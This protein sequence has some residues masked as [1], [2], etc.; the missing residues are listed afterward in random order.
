MPELGG[1]RH[2]HVDLPGYRAHVAEAGDPGGEPLVMVHGWPQ[3]WW[4]WHK[5]IPP[6]SERYRVICPDLRGHGWSDAPA[7]GYDKPQFARDLIALL[8]A[9]RLDRVRLMGHD[10]GGMAGFLAGIRAPERFDRFL[11]LGIAPPFPSGDPKQLLGLWRLYYQ[12]PLTLPVI[13]P[14]LLSRPDFFGFVLRRG[15]AVDGAMTSAD[16]DLYA[17]VIASRPEVSLSIYRTF[18]TR[19]LVQIASGGWAGPL[20]VPTRLLV[21]SEDTVVSVER[22]LPG[23]Q[24]Y[25]R[26]GRVHELDGVGHFVPEEA[27]E[28]VVETAL[29]FFA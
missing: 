10:W 11:A 28:A 13:A 5:V 24:R 12:L 1:V 22:A 15:T 20:T 2:S 27:P 4:C 23:M 25:A 18:I 19:E 21:G 3:H 29:A 6:L 7:G 16:I 9:L 14:R 8:D 26:D 17:E